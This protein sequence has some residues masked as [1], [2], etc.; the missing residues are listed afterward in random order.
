MGIR[1]R[2]PVVFL[3]AATAAANGQHRPESKPAAQPAATRAVRIEVRNGLFHVTDN[4]VLTVDRLDGWMIPRA[5]QVVSLDQK[6]SFTLQVAS[7]ETRMKASDLTSLLNDYLLPH[8]KT[9]IK[10][11]SI[12][13]N[14]ST[15]A[16]K[17]EF[18]KGMD[19]PFE[20]EGAVS[21]ARSQ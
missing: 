7:A 8:A 4:V 5:G 2:W 9:P 17:G 21:I 15:V 13:F 1:L 6:N 19:V 16:V 10:N 18:H 14:N 11:I 12:S 3:L 20:G